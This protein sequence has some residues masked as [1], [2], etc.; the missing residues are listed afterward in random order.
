MQIEATHDLCCQPDLLRP[1]WKNSFTDLLGIVFAWSRA[2]KRNGIVK[3][4]PGL[5]ARMMADIGLGKIG[6]EFTDPAMRDEVIRHEF[7]K[8]EKVDFL[9]R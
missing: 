3:P 8:L 9:G 7:A 5:D 6:S 1:K 4:L 2:P